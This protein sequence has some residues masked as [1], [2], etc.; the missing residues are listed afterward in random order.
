MMVSSPLGRAVPARSINSNSVPTR[1]GSGDQPSLSRSKTSPARVF[2]SAK[3]GVVPAARCD[4]S[5]GPRCQWS[6]EY[7]P[8]LLLKSLDV[9]RGV[10]WTSECAVMPDRRVFHVQRSPSCS[11]FENLQQRMFPKRLWQLPSKCSRT[12][13]SRFQTRSLLSAG[14]C[15]VKVVAEADSNQSPSRE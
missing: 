7:C 13:S 1:C 3:S 9:Q 6:S 8:A 5:E 11:V 14:V 2:A 10:R 4:P 15:S 12:L